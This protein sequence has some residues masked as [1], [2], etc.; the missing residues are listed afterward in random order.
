MVNKK[1][2]KKL[3]KDLLED[4]TIIAQVQMGEYQYFD[5]IITRYEK[6]IFSY[7][8]RFIKD[9]DEAS[10]VVQ[11]VFMKALRHIDSFDQERKLSSWLY[12]IAHNETM[13]WFA[14]NERKRTV[15]IDELCQ[16]KDVLGAA[17]PTGTALEEWF[18]I[19]L[20]DVLHD[21]VKQL[22]E[23][24]ADVIRMKYFEDRSYK[25]ISEIVGKPVSSVGTLIRRA[26]KR[27]L[28]LVVRSGR[29]S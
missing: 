23:Q 14:R 11:I 10:D 26:K 20:R 8:L 1:V 7:V 29:L 9:P 12:R 24:Y 21:A 16:T 27:L 4:R 3:C 6:C 13:N 28:V 15:S 18:H 17:D 25:E 5:C 22:P 19:E 2:D